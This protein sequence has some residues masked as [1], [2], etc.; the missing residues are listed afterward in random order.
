ML[1]RGTSDMKGGV[2][3]LVVA[4]EQLAAVGAPGRLVLALVADEEDAS[5]GTAA[6]FEALA[7]AACGRTSASSAEPTWL[8]LAVAHRG[9]AVV[10]VGLRGRAA[11]SSQPEHGVDVLAP[12]GGL[13]VAV[14]ERDRG[15]GRRLRIRCSPTDR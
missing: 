12:L 10:K 3:G 1:G 6:V 14:A 9:Y 7:S 5:L 4:A 13:L 15:C 2:A 11:H 8:D